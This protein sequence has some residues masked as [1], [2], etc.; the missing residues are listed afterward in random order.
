MG[1]SSEGGAKSSWWRMRAD[2]RTWSSCRA[3]VVFPDDV[4]PLRENTSVCMRHQNIMYLS[5]RYHGLPYG[6]EDDLLHHDFIIYDSGR[7]GTNL[8]FSYFKFL[9]LVVYQHL[10]SYFASVFGEICIISGYHLYNNY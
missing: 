7:E 5:A 8:F 2:G 4:G 3:S 10:R 6:D 1:I 9:L